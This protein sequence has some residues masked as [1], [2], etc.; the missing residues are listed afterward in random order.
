MNRYITI[1]D[2]SPN[3][4]LSQLIPIIVIIVQLK[5]DSNLFAY[6]F[7]SHFENDLMGT[8]TINL[9]NDVR[10][11]NMFDERIRTHSKQFSDD[12]QIY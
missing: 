11:T 7:F 10:L 12:P 9:V 1:N 8:I 3:H 2:V 6:F 4:D 5:N